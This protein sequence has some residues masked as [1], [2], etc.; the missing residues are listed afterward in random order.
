MPDLATV[1]VT[2]VFS[3]CALIV[4]IDE[5]S[6]A[7]V[8]IRVKNFFM[9]FIFRVIVTTIIPKF[10][11]FKKDSTLETDFAGIS[12]VIKTNI[13]GVLIPNDL[14]TLRTN[15]SHEIHRLYNNRDLRA[16]LGTNAKK[17]YINYNPDSYGLKLKNIYEQ[18]CTR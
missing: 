9:K 13:N 17:T 4:F 10:Y 1:L 5:T 16:T 15:L 8:K 11:C 14:V 18:I 12:Q 7:A 3:V 6:I 2:V